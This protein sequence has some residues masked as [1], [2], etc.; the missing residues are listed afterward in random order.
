[1][2]LARL[3]LELYLADDP[4]HMYFIALPHRT[5]MVQNA[6]R[7]DTRIYIP[8]NLYNQGRVLHWNVLGNGPSRF[9]LQESAALFGTSVI[10]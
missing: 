3:L 2:E 10:R 7:N 9:F 8:V 4:F 5:T 6:S 1:M